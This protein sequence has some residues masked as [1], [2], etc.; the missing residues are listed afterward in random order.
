MPKNIIFDIGGVLLEY[1]WLDMLMDY[2]LSRD[3]AEEIGR[4]MFDDPLWSELDL[5]VR[6]TAE[7]IRDFQ[8]KYP[9]YARVI[10]WFIT[11]GEFMHVGRPKVWEL[12]R[13]LKEKGYKLYILSN[14][15]SDLFSKHT[16][17]VPFLQEMDGVVVSYMI[18]KA[19]PNPEIYQYLLETYHLLPEESLFFDDRAEN[20]KAAREMGI[21]SITVTSQE[22][23]IEQL[24]Q[25][26]EQ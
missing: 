18:H 13:K 20:T 17:D 22:F 1:R 6:P 5:E 12:V 7:V 21:A 2:G 9:E 26:L 24:Q 11:H 25:L 4:K 15:S 10:A 19:K 8:K 23:L 3:E 16:K 14:Y